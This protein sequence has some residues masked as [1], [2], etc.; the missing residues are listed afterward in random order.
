MRT[1]AIVVALTLCTPWWASGEDFCIYNKVYVG[2]EI[3]ESTTVFHNGRVYDL[4]T[5]PAE[6]TIFDPPGN[7]FVILDVV[8]KIKTEATTE[9]VE[10][11]VRRVREEALATQDSLANFLAEPTFEQSFD[12]ASGE[13]VLK[14]DWMTY[15]VKT[16]P[17]KFES[18]AAAYAQYVVWQTK[19]NSVIRPGA[20]PPFARLRLN[21]ALAQ[22]GR[23]PVEVV[24]TRYSAPPLRKPATLRSEHRIQGVLLA[25]DLARVDEADRCLGTFATVSMIEFQRRELPAAETAQRPK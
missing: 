21:E 17:P 20:L 14:S 2:K 3:A 1:A 24:A 23:L 7:R 22:H 12:D 5:S 11:F 4:L 18:M 16:V 9:Q 25:S 13:L 10:G 8:R 15:Q 19:L 6:I